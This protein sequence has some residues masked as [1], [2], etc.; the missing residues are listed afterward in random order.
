MKTTTLR[1][2]RSTVSAVVRG[3][4]WVF[5]DGLADAQ[6]GEVVALR[7]ERDKTVGWGLA[8]DGPICVRVLGRGAPP[9]TTFE[10]VVAERIRRSDAVRPALLPP[11][12]NCWRVINGAGDGLPGLVVDRYAG[13]AV[14]RIYSRAWEVHLATIVDV[15][16]RL[17]WVESVIRRLGVGSVDG[18]KGIERLHGPDPGEAVLVQECGLVLLVRPRVGQKTGLFLDQRE[19][20][21]LIRR[22]SAGRRTANLFAY[23]GGFSVAAAAGGAA[24]VHTVDIA[25]HAIDDAREIF[26]LNGIDPDAHAFEVG[27]A[28][29][30]RPRGTLDLLVLDPPS[31]THGAKSDSAARSAYRKLHRH[32]S[33][34]VARDGLLA[35]SSCTARVSLADWQSYVQSGLAGDWSWSWTSGGPPDHPTA[36]AHDEARYLKFAVLRRR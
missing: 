21:A 27:D 2:S 25:R 34:S 4:P 30:W 6:A 33:P 17:P 5:R 23:N 20:R 31:L 22:W 10:R 14:V 11:D 16:S 18:R 32:H 28:F 24:R 3:H 13:L 7:D 19:H 8:D 35:T 29:A 36:L 26:R 1:A 12:T 15:L 9:D